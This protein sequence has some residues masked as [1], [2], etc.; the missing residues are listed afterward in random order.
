MCVHSLTLNTYVQGS[1][2]LVRVNLTPARMRL[3]EVW[4]DCETLYEVPSRYWCCWAPTSLSQ[5]TSGTGPKALWTQ[6]DHVWSISACLACKGRPLV[7]HKVNRETG[8]VLRSL[9]WASSAS[10]MSAMGVPA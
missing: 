6:I 2:W 7:L 8:A 3:T 5:A 4:A 10:S 1:I 9:L